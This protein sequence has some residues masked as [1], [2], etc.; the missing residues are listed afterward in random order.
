MFT[1]FSVGFRRLFSTSVNDLGIRIKQLNDK[2]ISKST[3]FFNERD[4]E[5]RSNSVVI[6]QTLRTCIELGD[7]NRAK[8]IHKRLPSYLIKNHFI[9]ASLIRLYSK[10]FD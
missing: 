1:L 3:S 2:T 5:Q 10:S 4:Q 8:D 6:N 7:F 9:S